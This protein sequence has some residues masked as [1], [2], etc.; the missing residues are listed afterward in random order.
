MYDVML[1]LIYSYQKN[2]RWTIYYLVWCTLA[3]SQ[4]APR[5]ILSKNRR[6]SRT[7]FAW[8]RQR[9]LSSYSKYFKEV[10]KIYNNYLE[11]YYGDV[12]NDFK[13]LE[14]LRIVLQGLWHLQLV[15]YCQ[16]EMYASTHGCQCMKIQ[17]ILLICLAFFLHLTN[18]F[19]LLRPIRI[20]V[21]T[22]R[23]GEHDDGSQWTEWTKSLIH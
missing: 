17:S 10:Q 15:A 3:L 7:A 8:C 11:Y 1:L 5:M 14:D 16:P 13:W 20:T 6:P 18:C 22:V 4:E 2:C 9:C 19:F 21:N 23:I 12:Y